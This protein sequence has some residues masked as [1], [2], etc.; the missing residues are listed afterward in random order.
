MK[1]RIL[2]SFLFAIIAIG[3]TSCKQKSIRYALSGKVLDNSGSPLGNAEIVL[4]EQK[5]SSGSLN[6]NYSF[7]DGLTTTSNGQF[8]FDFERA[9]AL[10]YKVEIDKDGFFS[11]DV[12]LNVGR[13]SPG[14]TACQNFTIYPKGTIKVVIKNTFPI[15]EFDQIAYKN[16]NAN[17]DC[18]CCDN[19]QVTFPGMEVD[20]TLICDLYA[21]TWI[22]YEYEIQKYG[23]FIFSYDS[24]F[25]TPGDTTFISINY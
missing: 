18:F 6:T 20:T 4:S 15:D 22:H 8:L 19:D 24:A 7:I 21:E 13:F 17:F 14:E 11:R 5:I 10:R 12:E 9:N 16:R 2:T 1:L 3:S 23:E 25:V